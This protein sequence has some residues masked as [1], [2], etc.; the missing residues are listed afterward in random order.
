MWKSEFGLLAWTCHNW[1]LD[2]LLSL[3]LVTCNLSLDLSHLS[4]YPLRVQS[5]HSCP[6][7]VSS[8]SWFFF[9]IDEVGF[10]FELE[11][12]F[13]YRY[14][15]S[16]LICCIELRV[17]V[18]TFTGVPSTIE[19]RN[20]GADWIRLIPVTCYFPRKIKGFSSTNNL[21]EFLVEQGKANW[22]FRNVLLNL[23]FWK[24]LNF[25]F[26][27]FGMQNRWYRLWIQTGLWFLV[28]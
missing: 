10:S 26:W 15:L 22:V 7:A 27:S 24:Y 12:L 17:A 20:G 19:S 25:G 4:S 2:I 14:L 13:S 3:M 5:I 9:V 16:K 6:S 18:R 28:C 23:G 1:G 8:H 11:L 21:S